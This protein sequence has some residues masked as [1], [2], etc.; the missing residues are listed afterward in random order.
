M[1]TV[2]PIHLKP[3]AASFSA[4]LQ[5]TFEARRHFTNPV[6]G[7]L[8]PDKLFHPVLVITSS[9]PQRCH[10]SSPPHTFQSGFGVSFTLNPALW[11]SPVKSAS[12]CHK[13]TPLW[14]GSAESTLWLAGQWRRSTP[15]VCFFS[16]DKAKSAIKLP[17]GWCPWKIWQSKDMTSQDEAQMFLWWA[18]V[19]YNAGH[20]WFLSGMS[21]RRLCNSEGLHSLLLSV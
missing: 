15:H 5:T 6:C 7:E 14:F 20:P 12:W 19:G 16:C 10:N 9:Q 11:L 4:Q 8:T 3:R 21:T 18:H 17:V 2:F 1:L 13:H